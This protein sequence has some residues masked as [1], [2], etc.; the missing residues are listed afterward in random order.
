MNCFIKM[1][2]LKRKIS[3]IGLGYVGLPVAIAFAEAGFEVV[4]YDTN[5]N[6]INELQK[7]YDKTSEVENKR[8]DNPN[9][10]Y[11][12]NAK[13][14]GRANFHIITVPT[15]ITTLNEPDISCLIKASGQSENNLK[16]V[17]LWSMSRRSI[18]VV[19]RMIACQ[20]LK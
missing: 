12:A 5:A 11:T 18:Q 13:D 2:E 4:G 14:I 9:V 15:P 6:R 7:C 10:T 3:V 19:P 8:L 16:L 17:T 20:C 1:A